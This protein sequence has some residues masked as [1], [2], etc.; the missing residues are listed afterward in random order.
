MKKA[1]FIFLLVVLSSLLVQAETIANVTGH[2]GLDLI[3]DR[4]ASDGVEI[5][6][7][8]IVKAV[9]KDPSGEYTINIG[10]FTVRK[11]FDRTAEG[12]IEI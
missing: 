3:I 10:I 9:F 4:G 5:G 2:K 12:A 6:M 8:G 7:K 11:V 1:T